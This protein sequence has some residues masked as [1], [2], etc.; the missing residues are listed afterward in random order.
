MAN[1]FRRNML[2]FDLG[3]ARDKPT[4]GIMGESRDALK[5]LEQQLLAQQQMKQACGLV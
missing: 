2:L 1:S 3:N 4:G 5:E